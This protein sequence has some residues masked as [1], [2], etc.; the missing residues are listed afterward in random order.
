MDKDGTVGGRIAP[1]A[2]SGGL[3]FAGRLSLAFWA[4]VDSTP[5]EGAERSAVAA[6]VSLPGGVRASDVPCMIGATARDSRLL[7][8]WTRAE[9]CTD[10]EFSNALNLSSPSPSPS[11]LVLSF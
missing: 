11:S 1:E 3:F 2:T 7:R 6:N 9:V 5:G 8:V 10:E 4:A